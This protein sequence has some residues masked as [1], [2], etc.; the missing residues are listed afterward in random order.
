MMIGHLY[1]DGYFSITMI[2]V[3]IGSPFNLSSK[4]EAEV[5]VNIVTTSYLKTGTRNV[6]YIKYSYTC[7]R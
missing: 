6:V 1:T 4:H 5:F 7:L 2:T 3:G